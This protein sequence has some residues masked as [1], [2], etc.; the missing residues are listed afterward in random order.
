MLVGFWPANIDM[1]ADP[2]PGVPPTYQFTVVDLYAPAGSVGTEAG[3]AINLCSAG[4]PALGILQDN[5]PLG[6]EGTI[7]IQGIS[8]AR[9]GTGGCTLGALLMS[10]GSGNLVA[11]TSTNHA[12]AKALCTATAGAITSVLIKSYGKI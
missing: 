7:M 5:P 6:V 10:D 3:A 2:T 11:A 8:K 9:I 4:Y 1:S 12:I